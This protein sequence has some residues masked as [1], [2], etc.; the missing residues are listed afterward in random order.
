MILHAKNVAVRD[1]LFIYA[2]VQRIK[3]KGQDDAGVQA[4]VNIKI[5]IGISKKFVM[6]KT[7]NIKER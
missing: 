2:E 7:N 4:Q 1:V 5:S 6:T 3:I